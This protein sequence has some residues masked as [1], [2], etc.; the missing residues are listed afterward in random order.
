[1]NLIPV[2]DSYALNIIK[3]YFSLFNRNI[4]RKL[5][6]KRLRFRSRKF[7]TNKVYISNGEFK[8]T[9]DKVIINIYMFNRQINNYRYLTKTIKSKLRRYIEVSK[10]LFF[11]KAKI[12]KKKAIRI[13]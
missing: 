2:T 3:I 11:K 10:D 1:M 4:E 9:N 6:T 5:R 13:S 12:L 8:H 7:T